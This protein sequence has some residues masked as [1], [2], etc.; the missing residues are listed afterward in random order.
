M[1]RSMRKDILRTSTIM[2][3]MTLDMRMAPSMQKKSMWMIVW[4][5]VWMMPTVMC[6]MKRLS[7]NATRKLHRHLI[8]PLTISS[9]VLLEQHWDMQLSRNPPP[10]IANN[11]HHKV[12]STQH[13]KALMP[14]N[15]TRR[16][17][18]A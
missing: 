7:K 15:G 1:T 4:M 6:T 8:L 5:I 16:L 3:T 12:L 13:H 2:K 9:S 17:K 18:G 10:S 11:K 14:Q